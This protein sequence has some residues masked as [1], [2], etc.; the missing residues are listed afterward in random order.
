LINVA[1]SVLAEPTRSL[2]KK[3]YDSTYHEVDAGIYSD[4]EEDMDE[5]EN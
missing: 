3:I 1:L 5:I 4:S 2:T